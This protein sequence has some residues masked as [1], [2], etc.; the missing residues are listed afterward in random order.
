MYK[1][2][3]ISVCLPCRNEGSHLKKVISRVP[4]YVDE[5]IV[6][7]NQSTDNTISV[8]K[9]CGAIV[10][11]ENRAING[12]GYGFAHIAGLKKATGDIIICADG[13]GTYPFNA[14]SELIEIIADQQID[15]ISCNRY[16]VQKDTKIP[17]ILKLG[18]W[19]LNTETRIL[20]NYNIQD[21]LS[22]MWALSSEVVPKL[23]LR[24]GDWNLSPEIKL[25]AI[26]N[27]SIRYK[28][29]QITQ[30]RRYGSTHQSY[31]RTGLS[32]ATWIAKFKFK[33]IRQAR[34]AD[35]TN[36]K[37]LR[38]AGIA[39]ISLVLDFYL[40]HF[41][42]YYMHVFYLI[43]AALAY[44]LSMTLN[45]IL[46]LMFVFSITNLNN[47][48]NLLVYTMSFYA[49]GLV[50]LILTELTMWFFSS[51]MGFYYMASKALS[52]FLVFFW[53]FYMRSYAYNTFK[54]ADE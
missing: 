12:I 53:S 43:S 23:E 34:P 47:G 10:I 19:L 21:I 28:E 7:S 51:G 45:Y 8:A 40:L 11:E 48:K 24:S 42:T 41:F 5:I 20:F 6:I 29:Y 25:K 4:K 39:F 26:T 15:M 46:C 52:C 27:K 54:L 2:K 16:P 50:G 1:D 13:D 49:I 37:I 32:H 35:Y 18:V 17:F 36:S 22:G 9:S 30:N 14:I 44:T 33:K 31:L 3:R 38:Y